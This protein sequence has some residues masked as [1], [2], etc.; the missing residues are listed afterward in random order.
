MISS[1]VTLGQLIPVLVLAV[2]AI[3]AWFTLK[4]NTAATT[5]AT[6]TLGA[7]VDK[8]DQAIEDLRLHVARNCVEKNDLK[9]VEGRIGRRIEEVEHTVRGTAA[10]IIAAL[11]G[12]EAPPRRP[13]R[14]S[15]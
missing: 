10:Q 3:G 5:K 12:T 2:T 14:P 8:T 13:R 1:D 15:P 9:E 7:R 11:T 4:A 6:E